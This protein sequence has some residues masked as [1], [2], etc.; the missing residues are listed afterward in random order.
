[1]DHTV[2]LNKARATPRSFPGA[3][4]SGAGCRQVAGC[5]F[6]FGSLLTRH[7]KI[8]KVYLWIGAKANKQ[9]FRESAQAS[10]E[11]LQQLRT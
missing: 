4:A 1:M 5:G 8:S 9:I 6:A 10:A 11:K 3:F 2:H 7:L